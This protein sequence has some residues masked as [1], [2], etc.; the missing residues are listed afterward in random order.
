MRLFRRASAQA[1]QQTAIGGFAVVDLETTGLYPTKDRIVEVGVVHMSPDGAVT[2]RLATLVN[3]QRDVGATRIHGL[4]AKD[5][6]DAPTFAEAAPTLWR[7]LAGRVVV[8]HNAPFDLRFLHQEFERCDLWMPELVA[9]CTMRLAPEFLPGLTGRSLPACCAAAGVRLPQHHAALVDAEA[10]AGLLRAFRATQR[11]LPPSW[12][13]A[14]TEAAHTRW[15]PMPDVNGFKPVT[16]DEMRSR[17]A[18]EPPPLARVLDELPRAAATE[19]ELDAYL[20]VLDRVLEDRLVTEAEVDQLLAVAAELGLD[21]AQAARA[22]RDYLHAVAVAAWEDGVVTPAERADLHELARLLGVGVDDAE[23]ILASA[24]AADSSVVQVPEGLVLHVGDR[25][26]FTGNTEVPREQLAARA[27]AAGLRV[28]SSV[29]HLTSLVVVEDALSQSAKATGARQHGVPMVVEQVFL[30][31]LPH[32]EPRLDDPT[33]A[34]KQRTPADGHAAPAPRPPTASGVQRVLLVGLTA[35]EEGPVR[36]ALSQAGAVAAAYVKPS[37]TA[38][39]VGSGGPPDERVARAAVL[40]VPVRTVD[41][42][43]REPLGRS[44]STPAVWTGAT[45]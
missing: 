17:H 10:A 15:E 3:P 6:A 11:Q 33:V 36:A 23:G 25:V 28:T 7:A 12:R 19:P 39:V 40:G 16:R 4:T 42:F 1:V 32:V 35:E 20:G 44:V 30:R 8:A 22:H 45:A 41:E 18:S 27:Q 34:P 2:E 14:L 31:L 9:L 21:R 13:Q 29:S 5:L 37:L 24:R 38:V 26:A 43:L